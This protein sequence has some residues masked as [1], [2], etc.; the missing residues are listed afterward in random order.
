MLL[1]RVVLIVKALFISLFSTIFKGFLGFALTYESENDTENKTATNKASD[2][3]VRFKKKVVYLV[4][5]HAFLSRICCW[6]DAAKPR[7]SIIVEYTNAINSRME[8]IQ[9]TR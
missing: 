5:I 2:S 4:E 3:L 1:F 9:S 7:V 6:F 8:I